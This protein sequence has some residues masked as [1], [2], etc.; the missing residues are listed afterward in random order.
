[1]GGRLAQRPRH[2]PDFGHHHPV[3]H[4]KRVADGCHQSEGLLAGGVP[5]HQVQQGIGLLL[6]VQLLQTLLCDVRDRQSTILLKHNRYAAL[7]E[8][9]F[10]RN[11]PLRYTHKI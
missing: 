8:R 4:H 10:I 1:M 11:D 6:R 5:P 2:L 9:R 3:L 7:S